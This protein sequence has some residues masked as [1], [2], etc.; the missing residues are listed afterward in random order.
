[1]HAPCSYVLA[2]LCHQTLARSWR[3]S[4]G[5]RVGRLE[6]MPPT[7][8]TSTS[9]TRRPSTSPTRRTSTSPTRR[10]VPPVDPTPLLVDVWTRTAEALDR[11]PDDARRARL[12]S[13]LSKQ[14]AETPT[15]LATPC[16]EPASVPLEAY[17][18]QPE[19][20]RTAGEPQL[21]AALQ[22]ASSAIGDDRTAVVR[23]PAGPTER[24]VVLEE[25]L[26][27][28][29][30]LGR[31]LSDPLVPE[32]PVLRLCV[33]LLARV[34]AER[35]P[36]R[37]V[38]LRVPPHVAVQCV[39]GPRHTRGTPPNVVEADPV[40]FLDVAFGRCGWSDAVTSGRIRASG[41]RA[42]LQPWLPLLDA[43][44]SPG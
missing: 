10:P 22:A 26:L 41:E 37:S 3:R 19:P 34:L 17:L 23:T 32:R 38:E 7:R 16:P 15:L 4:G 12:T 33:R 40:T 11:E 20:P 25:R 9:P 6:A 30:A 8:R 1:M 31:R 27:R 44:G 18:R 24:R 43:D 29:V 14:L 5:V 13:A 28:A 35:A 42:D 39:E 2:R 21:A 36:G